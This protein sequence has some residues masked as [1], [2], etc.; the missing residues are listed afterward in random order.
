MN[1]NV[2]YRCVMCNTRHSLRH[3]RRF[4][5]LPP[6]EKTRF[7][8]QHRVCVN[9]LGQ[10]HQV[11]SCRSKY[12]CYICWDSHHTLVHPH[13]MQEM[14]WLN[15][16]ACVKACRP[17][18]DEVKHTLRILLDPNAT[19]SYFVNALGFPFAVPEKDGHLKLQLSDRYNEVR[20][21]TV[22]LPRKCV[23]S[24]YCP[25]LKGNPSEVLSAY[26]QK[27]LADYAFHIPY[28][29][30]VIL[31]ADVAKQVYLNLPI[32]DDKL[33]FAQNTIFGWCF[34]G[35]IPIEHDL[36][37]WLLEGN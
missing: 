1:F 3:C 15:M 35:P 2:D 33:P 26:D 4:L 22:C 25:R 34:F 12:G 36:C 23:P 20:T 18:V 5:V 31:G 9:C 8:E 13:D 28:S 6:A 37:S 27:D 21:L 14:E 29:C 30:S 32:R 7:L 16:T 10:S 11:A 17:G 19:E 24:P